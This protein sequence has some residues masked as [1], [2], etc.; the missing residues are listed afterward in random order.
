M[1]KNFPF[2]KFI[3]TEWLTGNIVYESFETQ[4]IFINICALYWQRDGV[5]SIDDITKRF[6]GI[7]LEGGVLNYLSLEG[8]VISISFLD[9]QLVDA[10]HISKVNS[11]AGKES[12]RVRA[13]RKSTTVE[14]PLNEIQQPLNEIQQRKEKKRKEE[15]NIYK[16]FKHLMITQEEIDKILL[17]GYTIQEVN[18]ILNDIENYKKNTSYTSLYLTAL[19]WLKKSVPKGI[20]ENKDPKAYEYWNEVESRYRTYDAFRIANGSNPLFTQKKRLINER[21]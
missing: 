10:K 2:F 12:A 3:A 20:D 16:S 9:E 5:L 15:V 4:G 14:R 8:K 21:H 18:D 7:D 19:K 17:E 1:A 11:N 13:E 6:K